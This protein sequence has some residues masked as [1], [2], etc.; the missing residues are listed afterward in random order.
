MSAG[1]RYKFRRAVSLATGFSATDITVTAISQANPAVVTATAHGL[2]SGDVVK[3]SDVVGMVEVNDGVF[4]VEVATVDTFRLVGVDSQGYGAYVSGGVA[5]EAEFAMWC[6]LTDY[7][8]QG[9]TS[10]EIPATTQC[11]TAQEYEIGLPDYGTTAINYNFAP[12]T[13]I[14][15]ALKAAY[16]DGS[17]TAVKVSLPAAGGEMTHL[18]YVQQMSEQ[19]ATNGL[20]TASLTLRNTGPRYDV[21]VA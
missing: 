3:L 1:K 12:R 8:R 16:D 9:G 21:A 13:A 5:N 19:G 10:P 17:I 7:N 15:A 20:W 6:E 14:Q 11:S 2:V 18:G 4:I